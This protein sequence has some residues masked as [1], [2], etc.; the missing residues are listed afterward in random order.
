[1]R[2]L[3]KSMPWIIMLMNLTSFELAVD[4]GAGRRSAGAGEGT[5]T[6]SD[7]VTHCLINAK[8]TRC[9]QSTWGLLSLAMSSHF[10]LW[11]P[12][13]QGGGGGR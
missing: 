12:F 7:P 2:Q 10:W 9:A 6:Q 5:R 11:L 4:G 13:Q 1:M 8:P 3:M